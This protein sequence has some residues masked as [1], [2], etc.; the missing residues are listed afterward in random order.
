MSHVPWGPGEK[1]S[2]CRSWRWVLGGRTINSFD[3]VWQ[4]KTK[5]NVTS[6]G[7]AFPS[8]PVYRALLL[9]GLFC[10]MWNFTIN[11]IFCLFFSATFVSHLPFSFL[12]LSPPQNHYSTSSPSLITIYL[13]SLISKRQIDLPRASQ[14]STWRVLRLSLQPPPASQTFPMI[15]NGQP[16]H[17][18]F[19]KSIDKSS[20]HIES[21]H[22]SRCIDYSHEAH[23]SPTTR[24][25]THHN[26]PK[27]SPTS[28]P[29]A[30]PRYFQ[31]PIFLYL[32]FLFI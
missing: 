6:V 4:S 16:L 1:M 30:S 19:G 25:G 18:G 7:Q 14:L 12:L 20:K 28:P 31:A 10:L 26:T 17:V 21:E 24:T 29:F 13:R 2:G 27:S 32:H 9:R 23:T 5:G 3:I 15:R 11:F 8:S 22:R